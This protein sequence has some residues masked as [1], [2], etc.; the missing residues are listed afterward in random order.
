MLTLL[1]AAILRR[2][3]LTAGKTLG[4]ALGATGV[5]MILLP[6]ASLPQAND[7]VFVLFAFA[8]AACY[9]AEHLYIEM[10]LL[11]GVAIDR[12][13]F[14]MFLSATVMLIPAVAL[15]GTF[16]MRLAVGNHRTCDC[17]RG[18]CHP[19]RLLSYYPAYCLGRAGFHQSGG[20]YCHPCGGRLGDTHF[21]GP[22]F[23]LV[24]ARACDVDL[25]PYFGAPTRPPSE[26]TL[27]A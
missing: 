24:M 4:I 26:M 18:R 19:A 7:T 9:A 21:R 3:R 22:A 23:K 17:Q 14:I 8:G 11:H 6:K 13:L 15:T 10:K 5:G 12:L 25:R 27:G 20:L 2:E 16:Y 1:G